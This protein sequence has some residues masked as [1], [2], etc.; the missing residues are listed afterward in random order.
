MHRIVCR[1]G[2]RP[3][4]HWGSLQH[5]LRPLAAGFREPTST[6]KGGERRGGSRQGEEGSCGIQHFKKFPSHVNHNSINIKTFAGRMVLMHSMKRKVLLRYI[7]CCQW[8][9]N[10]YQREIQQAVCEPTFTVLDEYRRRGYGGL[11]SHRIAGQHFNDDVRFA[12]RLFAVCSANLLRILNNQRL[13]RHGVRST[14]SDVPP[15]T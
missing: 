10:H 1:L 3:R 13:R 8:L 4:S 12:P 5:S 2:L 6:E 9:S 11:N 15:I 7:S 14:S